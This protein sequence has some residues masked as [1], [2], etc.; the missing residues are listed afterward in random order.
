MA[1]SRL[2]GY[3]WWQY[4]IVYQIYPR[5]FQD[6]NGDGIGDL[7][8]IISRL[9]HLVL[10]RS[11]DQVREA[12]D[13]RPN[14][15]CVVALGLSSNPAQAVL[16]RVSSLTRLPIFVRNGGQ[17]PGYPSY[18]ISVNQARTTRIFIRSKD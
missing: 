2:A 16:S 10:D 3:A 14:K 1:Y 15:G 6:S 8:G 4:G 9:D 12:L 11:G 5:S 7:P 18:K 17:G 13:L